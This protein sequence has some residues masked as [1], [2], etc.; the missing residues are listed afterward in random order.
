MLPGAW[1]GARRYSP[2]RRH[3]LAQQVAPEEEMDGERNMT[4][5]APQLAVHDEKQRAM[6]SGR[7][8]WN[9]GGA[10]IPILHP[11]TTS[12]PTESGRRSFGHNVLIV[13]RSAPTRSSSSPPF[14]RYQEPD[15]RAGGLWVLCA[16]RDTSEV[17]R[18]ALSFCW[19]RSDVI[20]A[21]DWQQFTDHGSTIPAE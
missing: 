6:P 17:D 5:R 2:Q 14:W 7:A 1:A 10:P 16:N 20:D 19:Q 4:Q 15:E 21:G 9:A 13:E 3:S 18:D 12:E 11:Q 8:T